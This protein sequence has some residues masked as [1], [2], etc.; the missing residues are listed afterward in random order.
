M[1]IKGLLRFG[2]ALFHAGKEVNG[3]AFGKRFL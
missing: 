1:W 3:T 2:A